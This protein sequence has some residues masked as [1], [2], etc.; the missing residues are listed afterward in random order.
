MCRVEKEDQSNTQESKADQHISILRVRIMW[1]SSR[2]Q[3]LPLPHNIPLYSQA[4]HRHAED[5]PPIDTNPSAHGAHLSHLGK[6][7]VL[8]HHPR[9]SS[10]SWYPADMQKR[11]NDGETWGFGVNM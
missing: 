11:G 10:S 7:S 8:E 1:S 9:F 6:Q 4:R 3:C 5:G 2:R